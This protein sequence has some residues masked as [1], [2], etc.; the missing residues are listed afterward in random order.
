M[1]EIEVNANFAIVLRGD[2]LAIRE[3]TKAMDALLVA[4]PQ[5]RVVYKQTSASR[6]W[7]NEGDEPYGSKVV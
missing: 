1:T 3:V 6:L 5:V 4:I 7:I 2:I